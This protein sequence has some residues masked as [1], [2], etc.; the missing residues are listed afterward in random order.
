GEEL[1]FWLKRQSRFDALEP[2]IHLLEDS[3]EL[4]E[5]VRHRGL[6]RSTNGLVTV[7]V[8]RFIVLVGMPLCL[9]CLRLLQLFDLPFDL[10]N[11]FDAEITALEEGFERRDCTGIPS[12]SQRGDRCP[13][14]REMRLRQIGGDL[15]GDFLI[16]FI[17]APQTRDGGAPRIHGLAGSRPFPQQGNTL[18]VSQEAQGTQSGVSKKSVWCLA[19]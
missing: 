18:V 19:L 10:R 12:I 16:A 15:P 1:V 14:D 11:H 5:A 3:R 17:H 13:S 6:I 4:V 2:V 9:C 8:L 7:F